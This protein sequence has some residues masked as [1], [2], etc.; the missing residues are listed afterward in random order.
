MKVQ[1]GWK[2]KRADDS[3]VV[4]VRDIAVDQIVGDLKVTYRKERSRTNRS[5]LMALRD[6]SENFVLIRSIPPRRHKKSSFRRRREL[7]SKNTL[8]QEKLR[9]AA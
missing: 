4:I 5:V 3:E 6:F 1:I 2:Y 8:R 7:R 9:F